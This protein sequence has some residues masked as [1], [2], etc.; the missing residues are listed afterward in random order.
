MAL[1]ATIAA[2]IGGQVVKGFVSAHKDKLDAAN[3]KGAQETKVAMAE[4]DADIRARE[5]ANAV[6]IAEQGKWWTSLPR[7]LFAY[8]VWLYFAKLIIWDKVLGWGTTDPLGVWEA[9]V[10]GTVVSVY[11]GARTFEKIARIRRGR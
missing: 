2:A 3:T 9:G 8:T 10:A 1:F 5:S 6:L 7:P 4:I 11:F